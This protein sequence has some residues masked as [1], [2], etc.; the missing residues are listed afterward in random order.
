MNLRQLEFFGAVMEA[1]STVGAARI[2]HVSQPAVSTM[3][4]H[5]EDHLGYR[6]FYRTGGRL[7]PTPEAFALH[8]RSRVI[9]ESFEITQNLA[10]QLKNASAGILRIG[11]VPAMGNFVLPT[12][13]GRFLVDRN[14]VR[15]TVEIDIH[16]GI[17]KRLMNGH[18]D[19]AI[20]FNDIDYEA[21]FP[22]FETRVL[23]EGDMVCV[24]AAD[25]PLARLELVRPADVRGSRFIGYSAA[26]DVVRKLEHVFRP[27]GMAGIASV[28]VQHCE[29]ACAIAA[30]SRG[31]T[32][33]DEF[34]AREMI[35][36]HSLAVRPFS[37]R[38]A[39]RLMALTPRN[40]NGD[41]LLEMLLAD[42]EAA[43]ARVQEQPVAG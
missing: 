39:I 33:A 3:I 18:V 5:L 13:L 8:D 42:M 40:R 36:R 11:A 26:G 38:V 2:L 17:I 25:H 35:R 15:V 21:E 37:P 30:A 7:Q 6:L 27:E 32:I 10:A 16:N 31:V 9:F 34:T 41:R 43:V 4:R 14:D 22:S 23:G 19:A 1:G 28:E 20:V 12:A 29:T 24:V